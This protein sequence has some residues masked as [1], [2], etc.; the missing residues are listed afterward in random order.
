MNQDVEKVDFSRD[1]LLSKRE[2]K[3]SLQD[4]P[5]CITSSVAVRSYE[6]LY[7]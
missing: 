7:P 2:Q 5:S 3:S 1:S 6:D 4:Q